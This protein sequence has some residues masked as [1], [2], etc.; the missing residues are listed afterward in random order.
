MFPSAYWHISGIS[1]KVFSQTR[2]QGL[3]VTKVLRKLSFSNLNSEIFRNYLIT[4]PERMS[5]ITSNNFWRFHLGSFKMLN[6]KSNI[7]KHFNKT[8]QWHGWG[9]I[10]QIYHQ[11][12]SHPGT[13]CPTI[14]RICITE[15]V[16][17]SIFV[18]A[19]EALFT[20]T[21]PVTIKKYGSKIKWSW[22]NYDK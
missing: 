10:S 9:K 11:S 20:L 6:N 12:W 5:K 22:K 1:W 19:N 4:D 2:H 17:D 21:R 13:T 15:T 7:K 3:L 8:V 16:I 18:G 14:K